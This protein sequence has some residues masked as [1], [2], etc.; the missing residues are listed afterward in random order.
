M[1]ASACSI[2]DQ[3][4]RGM[5]GPFAVRAGAVGADALMLAAAA[6]EEGVVPWMSSK[7]T[8]GESVGRFCARACLNAS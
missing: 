2:P 5:R 4:C 6:L 1:I 8:V 3:R 7:G